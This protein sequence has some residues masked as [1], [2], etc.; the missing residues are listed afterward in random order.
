VDT[1]AG[2]LTRE[3]LGGE[4]VRLLDA[5]TA[6]L[7][8]RLDQWSQETIAE[9]AEET[10]PR[11]EP[12]LQR[13][14]AD[15]LEDGNEPTFQ[16]SEDGEYIRG[17]AGRAEKVLAELHKLS[18]REFEEFC[19]RVLQKLGARLLT[20]RG[21]PGD[22]CVDFVA[23]DISLTEPST[24]GGKVLVIGQAKRY[25][26]GLVSVSDLR[27]FVGGAIKKAADHEDSETFRRSLL[28]PVSFA[29][30][31]TSD[32]NAS[33]RQYARAVG[34]WYLNGVGIAQLAL[35]IGV[36]PVTTARPPG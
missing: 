34:L 16:L 23:R 12:A 28:A 31:A 8:K 32:F 22:E 14:A 36:D 19:G 24:T 17:V 33:A 18:P 15:A 35:R 27:G 10:M 7:G 20:V 30:W 13:L 21:Q 26:E 11:L 4:Y 2:W 1:V 25:R 9:L 3:S 5:L 29:F 6:V